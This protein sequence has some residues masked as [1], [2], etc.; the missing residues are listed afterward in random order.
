MARLA[1]EEEWDRFN[2]QSRA[3]EQ[4]ALTSNLVGKQQCL[5]IHASKC[6]KPEVDGFDPKTASALRLLKDALDYADGNRQLVHAE[7]LVTY[8]DCS[9]LH[10]TNTEIA[11]QVGS[12]RGQSDNC[13]YAER[14][15]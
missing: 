1:I 3:G 4:S 10:G 15:K 8:L 2:Q 9:V 11:T 14:G 12:Y 13:E 7:P 6:A 5:L